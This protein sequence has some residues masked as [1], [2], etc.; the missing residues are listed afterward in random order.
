MNLVPSSFIFE[1]SS[2][3]TLFVVVTTNILDVWILDSVAT[4]RNLL[5]IHLLPIQAYHFYKVLALFQRK[6]K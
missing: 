5:H 1:V 6:S 4:N 2:C 3:A